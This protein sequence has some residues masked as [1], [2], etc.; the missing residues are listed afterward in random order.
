MSRFARH[1]RSSVQSE[2]DA[3]RLAEVRGDAEA[4]FRH[5]ERAHVLGQAV[6]V[7][8]VR[9]HWQM[10]LWASRQRKPGEAAGQC[11]RLV[12]AAL[13]TGI[14]WVPEGNTGGAN[15]SGLRRMPVP[16]DLQRVIDDARR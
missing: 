13:L 10:L 5:L 7:E 15:V 2:L 1:I 3:A 12:A 11:W 6:I 14:G 16:A 4:A 8:H 9:V